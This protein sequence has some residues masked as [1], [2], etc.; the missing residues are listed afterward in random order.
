MIKHFSIYKVKLSLVYTLFYI[1]EIRDA[2]APTLKLGK[3]TDCRLEKKTFR[4]L[5][6]NVTEKDLF[7]ESANV[8]LILLITQ[9]EWELN[10]WIFQRADDSFLD[11]KK[12][13]GN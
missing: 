6:I 5:L 10:Y 12:K 9:K 1:L 2:K 11:L 13:S 3:K 4:Q 8:P 7:F